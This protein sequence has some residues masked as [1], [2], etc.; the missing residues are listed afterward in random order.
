MNSNTT[1]TA[2]CVSCGREHSRES[3]DALH[4]VGVVPATR[5]MSVRI[6]VCG[7]EIAMP[8]ASPAVPRSLLAM[9]SEL[10]DDIVTAEDIA[11]A[12]TLDEHAVRTMSTIP[13]PAPE[14]AEAA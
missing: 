6:C 8:V 12:R 14:P 11:T 4:W 10:P 7:A 5:M 2:V 13:A 1:E 3:F 9:L